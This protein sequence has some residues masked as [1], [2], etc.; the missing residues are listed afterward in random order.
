MAHGDVQR[1]KCK[2]CGC[3]ASAQ[4][5]SMFYFSKRRLDLQRIYSRLRGGSSMR[6]IGREF[7][8]SRTAIANAVLRL[9]RQSMA[10]HITSHH[11]DLCVAVL[12]IALI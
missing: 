12:R 9:G 2:R 1:Y 3:G 5:E 4:T 10:A 7:G 11:R 6:D 8:C